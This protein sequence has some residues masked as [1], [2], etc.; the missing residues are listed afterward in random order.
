MLRLRPYKSCDAEKISEWVKDRDV[1]MKWGGLLFGEFPINAGI[2]DDKYRLQN[3]GCTESDNFYPWIAFDDENGVVGHFIMRYI[4]GDNRILRFGW[5]VVDDKIRGKGYGTEMLRLGLK[6]AFEILNADVVTIGVY[7]NNDR[8]HNCYKKL[9]FTDKEIVEKEPW[10]V[11]EM[12]I[13]KSG[14]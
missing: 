3:G 13:K 14:L 11:I 8:A 2:I 4:N 9:G 10:N 12:E 5:V 6:Y 1:F 7:E